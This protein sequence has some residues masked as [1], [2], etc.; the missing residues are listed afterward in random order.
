[1]YSKP[2][3]LLKKLFIHFQ[4][5]LT[6]AT[7]NEI[8]LESDKDVQKLLNKIARLLFFKDGELFIKELPY[9]RTI[10]DLLRS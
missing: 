10:E 2:K 3:N 4:D 8:G 1:V 5:C 6:F 7:Q 9:A